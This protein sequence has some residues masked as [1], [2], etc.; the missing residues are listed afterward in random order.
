MPNDIGFCKSEPTR[1]NQ[2]WPPERVT[3]LLA[4]LDAG[5]DYRA[6][7]AELGCSKNAVSGK[8]SRLGLDRQPASTLEKRLNWER[9]EA[10]GCR[11]VEGDPRKDW[12]WCGA[13][14]EAGKPYCAD[15][16]RRAWHKAS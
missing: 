10:K 6:I 16:L 15:H 5:M 14:Q 7:S 3:R 1:S 13:P 9:V 11:W 2:P 12:H 4:L 8:V